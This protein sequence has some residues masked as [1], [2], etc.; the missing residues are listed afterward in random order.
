MARPVPTKGFLYLNPEAAMRFA[1]FRC[2]HRPPPVLHA[3]STG[4]EPKSQRHCRK[5]YDADM[6]SIM[7]NRLTPPPPLHI[8]F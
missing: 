8:S 2:T 3:L 7:D 1:P 5:L 6:M 4:T